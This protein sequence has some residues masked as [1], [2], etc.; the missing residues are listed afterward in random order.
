M[1]VDGRL[2]AILH[3][4]GSV[5]PHDP[6]VM[7][8]ARN[9]MSIADTIMIAAI[10]AGVPALVEPRILTDRFQNVENGYAH[11]EWVGELKP[12]AFRGSSYHRKKSSNKA[13]RFA[14]VSCGGLLWSLRTS[15][16]SRF[17]FGAVSSIFGTLVELPWMM[18]GSR[19]VES[20]GATVGVASIDF[21]N[22]DDNREESVWGGTA[23]VCPCGVATSCT[24]SPA[25]PRYQH[26]L[27]FTLS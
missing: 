13:S 27:F 14:G 16:M 21:P 15:G 9:H 26:F 25:T 18:R 2:E 3:S 5:T 1:P 10:K 12:I 6:R 20:C 8:T 22:A 17:S 11:G 23:S 4:E 7:T 24:L 19:T